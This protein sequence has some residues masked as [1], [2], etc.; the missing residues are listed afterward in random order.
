MEE[1]AAAAL[2]E[3]DTVAALG[4][5]EEQATDGFDAGYEFVEFGKFFPAEGAPAL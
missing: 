5:F 1:D 4:H 2:V 3:R